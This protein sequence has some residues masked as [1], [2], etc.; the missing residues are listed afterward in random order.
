MSLGRDV[1]WRRRLAEV[2]AT[3]LGLN[4]G[5]VLD[6][7][8]GTGDVPAA[9]SL[10][11]P[12]G[13]TFIGVD[14]AES[15]LVEAR[16]KLARAQMQFALIQ[17]DAQQLPI[18]D[19]SVDCAT[20]AFGVRNF[21]DLTRGLHSIW[22]VLKPGGSLVVL[23]FSLPQGLARIPYLFYLRHV[24]PAIGGLIAGDWSAYRH[25]NAT[26]E[27]FPSGDDFCAIMTA[28][29]YANVRA[30]PLTFGVATI[31]AGIKSA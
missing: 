30:M 31:Y 14:P 17:G 4:P 18:R 5:R 1:A 26:I 11:V 8:T 10:R 22:R 15:M 23:E 6:L 16:R 19:D 13:T 12:A 27:K 24:I 9:L 29:G 25:L 7:A 20:V 2:C 28:A 21:A 3:R